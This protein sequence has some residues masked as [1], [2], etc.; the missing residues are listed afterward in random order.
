MS[1]LFSGRI[2]GAG[3]GVDWVVTDRVYGRTGVHGGNCEDVETVSER[4]SPSG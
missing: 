4:Q 3:V 2:S 1:G